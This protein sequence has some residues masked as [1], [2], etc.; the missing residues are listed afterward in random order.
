MNPRSPFYILEL[1]PEATAGDIERQSKKLLGLF[2]VGA[3][4]ARTYTCVLG[5]FPRDPTMVREAAMALRDPKVRSR[6]ACLVR[7]LDVKDETAA[8]DER[9]DPDSVFPDAFLVAGLRGL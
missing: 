8:K 6:E 1:T 3:E 5:S 7:L 4:R 2:D 9:F